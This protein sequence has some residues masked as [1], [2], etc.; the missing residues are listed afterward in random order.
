MSIVL[1]K[2]SLLKIKLLCSFL[3]RYKKHF[4][5]RNPFVIVVDNLVVYNQLST[6]LKSRFNKNTSVKIFYRWV[7]GTL[8]NAVSVKKLRSV[9]F[10]LVLGFSK[11]VD[12]ACSEAFRLKI[13]CFSFNRLL[14]L[15]SSEVS[16]HSGLVVSFVQIGLVCLRTV[17]K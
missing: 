8:T 15:Y 12:I 16:E 2:F 10:V 17:L 3:L 14:S 4:S 5:T 9:G 11:N 13:P 7:P 6:I 1:S